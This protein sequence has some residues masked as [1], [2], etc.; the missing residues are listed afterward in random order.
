MWDGLSVLSHSPL[1][2]EAICPC[3]PDASHASTQTWLPITG[4]QSRGTQRPGSNV[5]LY[6]VSP[7]GSLSLYAAA[8]HSKVLGILGEHG[9]ALIKP[10][11]CTLLC[12]LRLQR[13]TQ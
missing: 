12:P 10:A 3:C 6:P 13:L 11:Y 2:R 7:R 4:E 8:H 1:K 5:L 9:K